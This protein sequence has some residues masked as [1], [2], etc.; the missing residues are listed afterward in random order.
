MRVASGEAVCITG[1]SGYVGRLVAAALLAYED[2]DLVIPVREKYSAADIATAVAKECETLGTPASPEM[3]RRLHVV[4]LPPTSEMASLGPLL[5][6]HRVRQI[7]HCAGSLSYFSASKLKEGNLDL[8]RA[9]LDVA[10]ANGVHRFLYM[11]T[12]FSAGFV[13]GQVREALHHDPPE[14][15]TE[16]T[17]SKRQTEHMVADSGLDYVILRPSIVIG[18]SRSG[19]YSGRPYGLYQLWNAGERFMSDR[20][21]PVLHAIAPRVPLQVVHQDA[22][23]A[24]VLAAYREIPSGGVLHIVSREA[25]LPTVREM[26]D[27]WF[28]AWARPQEMHYYDTLEEVPMQELDRQQRWLV[29]FAAANIEISTHPWHFAAHRLDALRRDGLAFTDASIETVANSQRVFMQNSPRI[30]R[31][32]E[33]HADKI[34]AASATA[35]HSAGSE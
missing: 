30:R 19:L 21:T 22:V 17:R 18:H 8:T 2:V 29:E 9:L 35:P 13:A 6:Q 32:L 11:S 14:D 7:I 34:P 33:A 10:K 4:A 20:Y 15:P 27:L 26:W 25:S 3:L 23:Q 28:G 31:F 1:A 24:A 16:Y 5:R 12:A